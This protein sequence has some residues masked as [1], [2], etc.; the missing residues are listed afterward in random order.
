M[1]QSNPFEK[2]WPKWDNCV[3]WTTL[4]ENEPNKNLVCAF[5]QNDWESFKKELFALLESQAKKAEKNK[6]KQIKETELNKGQIYR[7]ARIWEWGIYRGEE[8]AFHLVMGNPHNKYITMQGTAQNNNKT[9]GI[10]VL[11][12]KKNR[13]KQNTVSSEIEKDIKKILQKERDKK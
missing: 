8:D 9:K 2:F 10:M 12:G 1:T 6:W 5:K 3:Y 7:E 13:A 4:K 11:R